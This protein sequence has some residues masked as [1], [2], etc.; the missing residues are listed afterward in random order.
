MLNYN[1]VTA[2]LLWF[3][4]YYI[5]HF[6]SFLFVTHSI[7]IVVAAATTI[8]VAIKMNVKNIILVLNTALL[9]EV[10]QVS[11]APITIILNSLN[12]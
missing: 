7:V 2:I 1:Y 8:I 12:C 5:F 11:I 4:K 10:F 6:L 9:E 3:L